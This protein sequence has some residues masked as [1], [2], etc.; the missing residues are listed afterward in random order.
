MGDDL[1]LT[2]K[3]VADS[4]LDSSDTR[5]FDKLMNA[6]KFAKTNYSSDNPEFTDDIETNR[7]TNT[8]INEN[9]IAFEQFIKL[10]DIDKKKKIKKTILNI[11]SR[12]RSSTYTYDSQDVNYNVTK[13]LSFINNDSHFTVLTGEDNFV[14]DLS[15]YKQ[16]IIR[17]IDE[18]ETNN[19]G[20][21]KVDFEFDFKKGTPI[22]N[23]IE[24]RYIDK[25]GNEFSDNSLYDPSTEQFKFNKLILPIPFNIDSSEIQNGTAGE[26]IKISFITN[27]GISYPSPSHYFINLGKT[28]SNI[29]SIRLVSSEIPNTSYTFNENL[30]ETNFGQFKLTT[31]QN[32][33]LRWINKTDRVHI[34]NNNVMKASIFHKNMPILPTLSAPKDYHLE[35]FKKLKKLCNVNLKTDVI[36]KVAASANIDLSDT[37]LTQIEGYT[38]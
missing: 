32:N 29:Y 10:A 25:N 6:K 13:P 31:K 5:I 30:I 11:D 26:G 33:K 18:E 34:L 8:T 1:L 17:D 20:I 37:S 7:E 3:Y 28:F 12:N 15:I 35:N 14:K 19:V 38:L 27:V 36:V 16:I 4:N 22:F 21:K 23:I 24:F 2:N 9:S